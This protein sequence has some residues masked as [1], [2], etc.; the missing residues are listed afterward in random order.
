MGIPDP[1]CYPMGMFRQSQRGSPLTAQVWPV[2]LF[3]LVTLA[4]ESPW[5]LVRKGKLEEAERS[6]QRLSCKDEKVNPANTVAMMVRSPSL[7]SADLRSGRINW[8]SI[9]MSVHLILI[10][11]RVS[12]SVGP[13]SSA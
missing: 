6:V 9:T 7:D 11:S 2:P 5:Y 12:T 13:R 10:A 1:I 3:I 8:R 4:P